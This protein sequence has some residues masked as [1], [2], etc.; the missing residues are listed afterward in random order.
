MIDYVKDYALLVPIIGA[1]IYTLYQI[2][3]FS[4]ESKAIEKGSPDL[5]N[6]D[7]VIEEQGMPPT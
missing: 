4:F 7:R 1:Y 3:N 5:T 2:R 6:I